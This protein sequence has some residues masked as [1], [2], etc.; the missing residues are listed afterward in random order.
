MARRALIALILVALCGAAVDARPGGGETYSGRS[1]SS[2]S[3]RSADHGRDDTSSGDAAMAGLIIHLIMRYP[4]V[5]LT[6]LLVVFSYVGVLAWAE[7]RQQWDSPRTADIP[8]VPSPTP[9][10]LISRVDPDF[11]PVLFEDFVFRLYATA[12]SCRGSKH[13]LDELA[14]YMSAGARRA[15]ASRPPVDEPVSGVV[16]GAMRIYRVNVPPADA[17]AA[18]DA[19]VKVGVE[20]EAN[21]TVGTGNG[22]KRFAIETWLFQ[23]AA[24]ARTHPPNQ[25]RRFPCPNCG[26]PWQTADSA[27]T[28]KCASCGEVVDNGRFDWQVVDI[29]LREER[30]DLPGLTEAVPERGTSSPTRVDPQFAQQWQALT[31]AD[32]TVSDG[33]VEARLRHI[34][35]VVNTAWTNGDIGQARA[36]L[37]DALADYLQYW[38]DAYDNQGLRNVLEDM[39]LTAHTP[40]KLRRDGYYD[41]L[42]VR[43]WATGRDYVL[44]ESKDWVLRGSRTENREYSEYW[45]LIRAKGSTAAGDRRCAGCGAILTVTMAG[46]CEHCGAHVT[47][48]AIDWV[49]S[50]IE[51]DDSY[52]G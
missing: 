2:S 39:R 8:D 48:G 22:S 27:G 40:V 30:T 33:A 9:A 3:T 11:S 35:D 31:A 45:T 18:A 20:F 10:D 14:P 21:Y 51:Q 28:Q 46:A 19:V 17:H 23:R 12:Q 42:T 26:A 44:R 34:Y 47:A 25:R 29:R 37:S 38:L 32:A 4:L 7:S 24:A 6:L 5:V 49:L 36:V 41:A 52:Q 43:I 1:D 50:K 15:L 16:V 13:Q